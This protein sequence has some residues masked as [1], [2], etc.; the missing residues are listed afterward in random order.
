MLCSDFAGR[1]SIASWLQSW[2]GP[3]IVLVSLAAHWAVE[4]TCHRW[5]G[6]RSHARY[7]NLQEALC[8]SKA[9]GERGD[10]ILEFPY[11]CQFGT[12][13]E[14]KDAVERAKM[15]EAGDRQ[16]QLRLYWESL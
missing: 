7:H 4:E 6:F 1:L 3:S 12:V 16:A 14:A 8:R 5:S 15:L 10:L 13:P 11:G 9:Q 2:S